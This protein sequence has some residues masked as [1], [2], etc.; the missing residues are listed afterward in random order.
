MSGT[1]TAFGDCDSLT[2][3][4]IPS[5]VRSIGYGA[6]W[7][8]DSLSAVT[9]SEGVTSIDAVAFMNCFSLTAITLPATLESM[10]ADVFG[11]CTSLTDVYYAGSEDQWNAIEGI[12][13]VSLPENV[14]IHFNYL[15]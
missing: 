11:G 10:G 9:I 7:Y 15:A 8:C 5:G 2:A 6:F 13:K 12:E 14:T 1:K 4:T 3:V